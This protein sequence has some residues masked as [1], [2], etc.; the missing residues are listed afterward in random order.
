MYVQ[1]GNVGPAT[2]ISGKELAFPECI[3]EIIFSSMTL[4]SPDR[5]G[6][7]KTIYFISF[8][9]LS[10]KNV[11]HLVRTSGSGYKKET[12]HLS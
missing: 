4:L 3:Q 9:Q 2:S 10:C 11:A 7:D 1:L 8:P 6:I 5:F 12:A